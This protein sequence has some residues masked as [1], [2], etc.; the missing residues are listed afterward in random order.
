MEKLSIRMKFLSTTNV[1][2]IE[3]VKS[4]FSRINQNSKRTIQCEVLKKLTILIFCRKMFFSIERNFLPE[5]KLGEYE[6][7][8]IENPQKKK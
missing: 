3:F 4:V 6:A 5:A 7:H 2:I 1:K 8:I